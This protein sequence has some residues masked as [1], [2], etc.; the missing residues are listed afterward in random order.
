MY[1]LRGLSTTHPF[2]PIY[3]LACL[4]EGASYYAGL[5]LD[6]TPPDQTSSLTLSRKPR[7]E[8]YK[9]GRMT[10]LLAVVLLQSLYLYLHTRLQG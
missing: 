8:H 9:L 5:C 7:T 3:F 6:V 10:E 1:K 4:E 2:S